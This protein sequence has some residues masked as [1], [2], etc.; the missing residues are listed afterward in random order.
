MGV[1]ARLREIWYEEGHAPLYLLQLPGRLDAAGDSGSGWTEHVDAGSVVRRA[2]ALRSGERFRYHLGVPPRGTFHAWL[3]GSGSNGTTEYR[4]LATTTD[5]RRYEWRRAVALPAPRWTLWALPFGELGDAEVDLELSVHGPDGAVGLWGNPAV[6]SR[7][8]PRE[9]AALARAFVSLFGVGAAAHK[10]WELLQRPTFDRGNDYDAW[11]RRRRSPHY[12][13]AA[14]TVSLLLR[15]SGAAD[16][17]LRRSLASLRAQT[18]TRWQLCAVLPAERAASLAGDPRVTIGSGD[19]S[20][21]RL[22]SLADGDLVAALD[23]GDELAPQAL[24]AIAAAFADDGV[25]VAYSDEDRLAADGCHREPFFKPDWSP[26]YFLASGYTGRLTAWR[27][28]AVEAAGGFRPPL[29]S[30]QEF[31]LTLRLVERGAGVRHV[32]DVLYHRRGLSHAWNGNGADAEQAVREHF[33]RRGVAACGEAHARPGLLHI[34]YRLQTQPLVSIVIP[35]GGRERLVGERRVD[36]LLNCL[37]S[38]LRH[39]TYERFEILCIDDDNLRPETTAGLAAL[40]DERIRL[41]SF[42]EGPLNIAAKMN[43]GVRQARGE[44]VLF[45]NDDI[46]VVTPDW[47]EALLE[48][49][50]QPEIGAVGPKL[51]YPS[52]AIQHGGMAVADRVPI[53]L[54]RWSPRDHPGYFGSLAVPCNRS[55]LIGACLMTRRELFSAVGGFD[56]TMPFI[57]HDLDYC[58]AVRAR[59]LR[60]VFTPYAELYHFETSSRPPIFRS[61]DTVRMARKWGDA[62]ARDPFY[63]RHFRQ[64]RVDCRVS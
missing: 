27:R 7:R 25:D 61:A 28:S 16:D 21:S 56:V 53:I 18:H 23:A 59:G 58:F 37:H 55:A 6:L 29:G 57:W 49:S 17:D 38:I 64:D 22:L 63:S 3:A 46:E 42:R 52:G 30:A 36:L 62:L 32:D 41:M 19:E 8:G 54:F 11:R 10:A 43:F 26:E 33:A 12:E 15:V 51:L 35:T 20:W 39:T 60:V 44:Q 13:P 34:R 9:I 40:G 45:L 24:A 48:F 1:A 31:D 5:G 50:Q 4:L 47:I 2:I 14:L